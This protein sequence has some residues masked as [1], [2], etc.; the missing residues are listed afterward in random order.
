M[1]ETFLV[2]DKTYYKEAQLEVMKRALMKNF[3]LSEN[4]ELETIF[5][6]NTPQIRIYIKFLMGMLPEILLRALSE[7]LCNS[8]SG[9]FLNALANPNSVEIPSL[10]FHFVGDFRS[11]EFKVSSRDEKTLLEASEK[12]M[13]KLLSI[14]KSEGF[15]SESDSSTQTFHYEDGNWIQSI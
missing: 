9:A 3:L 5:K 4:P 15:F 12:V 14:V 10:I 13:D 2:E 6:H 8:I 1:I 11:I 7:D